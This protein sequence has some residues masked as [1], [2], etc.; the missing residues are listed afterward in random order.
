MTRPNRS[1]PPVHPGKIG[2][3]KRSAEKALASSQAAMTGVPG[4]G[5]MATAGRTVLGEL[6]VGTDGTALK[7]VRRWSPIGNLLVCT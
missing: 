7:R 4:G 5:G 1:V 3:R 6:G 2:V